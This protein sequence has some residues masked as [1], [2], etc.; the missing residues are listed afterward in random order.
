MQFLIRLNETCEIRPIKQ[1]NLGFMRFTKDNF[2]QQMKNFIRLAY[3]EI[4]SINLACINV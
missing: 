2:V 4:K 1:E 3:I